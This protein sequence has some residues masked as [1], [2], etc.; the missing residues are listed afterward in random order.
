[1]RTLVCTLGIIMVL[2]AVCANAAPHTSNNDTKMQKSIEVARCAGVTQ[3]MITMVPS[4]HHLSRFL[5]I[6]E[7]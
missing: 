2:G 3:G 6:M 5:C 1:M 7:P 4:I